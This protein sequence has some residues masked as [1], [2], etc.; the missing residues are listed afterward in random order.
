MYLIEKMKDKENRKAEV[1]TCIAVVKPN[2]E[3]N[4]YKGI[5]EVLFQKR[6]EEIMDLDL[7]KFLKLMRV[8]L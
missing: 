4:V 6:E 3:S 2:G 8:E 1:I 5:L 7:M